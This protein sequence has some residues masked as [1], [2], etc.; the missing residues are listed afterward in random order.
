MD[1]CIFHTNK[2][3]LNGYVRLRKNGKRYYAHRLIYEENFGPITNDYEIDH[4]CKNRGCIN[5]EHLEMVTSKENKRRSNCPSGINH[6]KIKCI[7]GH[8]F[9]KLNTYVW[10]NER[11]CKKCRSDADKMRYYTKCVGR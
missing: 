6:K 3:Q 2:P 8:E 1:D 7:R 10:K 5:P 4:L 9:T 11:R